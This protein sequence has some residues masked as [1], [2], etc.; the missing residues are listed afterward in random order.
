MTSPNHPSLSR[1][2]AKLR[3]ADRSASAEAVVAITF[4]GLVALTNGM[5]ADVAGQEDDGFL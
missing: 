4:A 3:H 5:A 2:S 1:Q